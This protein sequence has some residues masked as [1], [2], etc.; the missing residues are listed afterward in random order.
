MPLPQKRR[1]ANLCG[2]GRIR[3]VEEPLAS[4]ASGWVLTEVHAS[5]ISPGSELGGW[6]GLAAR[7]ENPNPS[8]Q[9]RPFGYS[10]AGVVLAAGPNVDRLQ[11]GDRV[12]CIGG[13]YAQ[14]ADYTLVPQNLCVALPDEV[15]FVQ[16]SYAML[17]ATAV[18]ALRR[19][20]TDFGELAAV[21]GLGLV[22]QL[23]AQMLKLA[24]CFVIGWDSIP[25]R[26][27]LARDWGIDAV[28]DIRAEDVVDITSAFTAGS[29]LDLAV[30]AFGGKADTA[31]ANIGK[32]MKVAP[33]THRMGRVVIVGRPEFAWPFRPSFNVDIR[34]AG[35]T[36][37]G[38]HDE[39]WEIGEAYPSVF[40]RWTTATNLELCMRLIAAGRLDVDCLTT[41]VIRFDDLEE[42]IEAIVNEPDNALGVAFQMK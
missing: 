29:G 4:P 11:T 19:A 38:Y 36:G 12:A 14:H 1:V 20:E 41:H 23:T 6:H 8:M 35:R 2:D 30:I 7:V 27:A 28:A 9:P 13:G 15:T 26:L 31:I 18:H 22:G 10:N 32:S 17:S 25:L 5:L 34:Q 37:P 21:A 40:V 33:D 24:G 16:G 3:L 39:D 42:E